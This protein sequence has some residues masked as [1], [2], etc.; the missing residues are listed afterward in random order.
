MAQLQGI[1][2]VPSRLGV[3]VAECVAG[4]NHLK[5]QWPSG[6]DAGTHCTGFLKR[7][8]MKDQN[9]YPGKHRSFQM[10]KFWI[11]WLQKWR[12]PLG[13]EVCWKSAFNYNH[14]T[15]S[16][17]CEWTQEG[18]EREWGSWPPALS[19]GVPHTP[20]CPCLKT[21][22]C[23]P[24]NYGLDGVEAAQSKLSHFLSTYLALEGAS[25]WNTEPDYLNTT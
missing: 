11:P 8:G 17:I 19:P 21:Q 10:G 16:E 6:E 5:I 7:P 2:V 25:Y 9:E 18:I 4:G 15:C 1:S 22:P 3:C 14:R 24:P 13:K 23:H 20:C 12:L